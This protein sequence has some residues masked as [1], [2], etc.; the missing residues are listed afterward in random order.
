MKLNNPNKLNIFLI[1]FFLLLL[2]AELNLRSKISQELF[3]KFA[4]KL[5]N[6][7]ELDNL[8]YIYENKPFQ[9]M[10]YNISEIQQLQKKYNLPENYSFFN[11]TGIKPVIKNQGSCGCCWSFA[12]STALGY[13]FNKKGININLS[14]QDGLSC[15]YRDCHLGNNLI[16]SH[17]NL[18]KNG[19]LTEECFPYYSSGGQ[20]IPECP[21]KCQNSSVEFKK[22]YSKNA[23]AIDNDYQENFYNIVLLM[24]DQLFNE[25]PI[26]AGFYIYEDFDIFSKTIS[27]CKN[28]IY[29]YDGISSFK[30]GHAIAIVGYG[31]LNNKFFWL[32]QNSWGDKWCDNGFI[33][34]EIGQLIEIAFSE[35][36][37]YQEGTSPI[38]INVNFERQKPDCNLEVITESSLSLEKWKDTMEVIFEHSE[39]KEKFLFVIGKN[40]IL[41]Q[42][43][44]NCFFDDRS[45]YYLPKGEYHFLEGHS[46]GNNNIFKLNN[47]KDIKFIF[48]GKDSVK[49]IFLNEIYVSEKGSKIY[50]NHIIN[51]LNKNL[52]KMLIETEIELNNCYNIDIE[53]DL[54][55]NFAYCQI[56]NN[57]LKYIEEKI[58]A[59]LLYSYNCNFASNS[60]IYINILDKNKY[61]IFRI[62]GFLLPNSSNIT[63][64]TKLHIFSKLEGSTKFYEN[65]P[66]YFLVFIKIE[67][68]NKNNTFYGSCSTQ[69]NFNE[70]KIVNL[71][72]TLELDKKI[73]LP[74]DNIYLLPFAI[75]YEMNSPYE[76]LIDK[77]IKASDKYVPPPEPPEPTSEPDSDSSEEYIPS[78]FSSYLKVFF[79]YLLKIFLLL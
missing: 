52:P 78:S 36:Y 37:I 18:V 31:L 2:K 29:S 21:N 10:A 70:N 49:S 43:E 35:P 79:I 59:R 39:T 22:Y 28:D 34:M 61:P 46:L 47:F 64:Y 76:V 45:L 57:A 19:T 5:N 32:I 58:Q 51:G 13:R 71:T 20:D 6:N 77:E 44:I 73:V 41:K 75:N 66:N 24:M 9:K 15:Y 26:T 17:L 54:N 67:N 4:K 48:N 30:G 23:Y 14:P 74:F 8:D 60:N 16:N 11:S 1:T 55:I 38:E 33:K 65:T 63:R 53:N 68:N 72:C 25:G 42:Q 69:I 40:D 56:D 50:F 12:T 7:L 3:N 27:K 62:F